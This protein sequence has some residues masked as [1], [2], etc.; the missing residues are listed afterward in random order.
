MLKSEGDYGNITGL[1]SFDFANKISFLKLHRK[2]N[3]KINVLKL[4][5][6][7]DKIPFLLGLLLY[8]GKK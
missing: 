7:N 2:E 3:V 5:L 1:Y 6:L 8:A 4:G